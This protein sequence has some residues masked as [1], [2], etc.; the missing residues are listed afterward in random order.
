MSHRSQTRRCLLVFVFLIG[1]LLFPSVLVAQTNPLW[2]TLEISDPTPTAGNTTEVFFQFGNWSSQPV[3]VDYVHCLTTW[4]NGHTLAPTDAIRA[5]SV[6]NGSGRNV[7]FTTEVATSVR[8]PLNTTLQP[9]ENLSFT[10]TMLAER[11]A[12]VYGAGTEPISTT[13]YTM[14]CAVYFDESNSGDTIQI[15][16]YPAAS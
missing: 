5:T 6:V 12:Y 2:N 14:Q 15:Y 11:P 3:T 4:F 10:M 16:V 8:I 13:E 7:D 9:W 1:L